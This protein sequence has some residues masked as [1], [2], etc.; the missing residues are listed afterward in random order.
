MNDFRFR[1][2]FCCFF[3]LC[4]FYY[5]Y[6]DR[7]SPLYAE[8]VTFLNPT[9][10]VTD[11]N[12]Y[13]AGL[14]D[15]Q[16]KVM[17]TYIN[18]DYQ[19]RQLDELCKENPAACKG[20]TP[21][22]ISPMGDALAQTAAQMLGLFGM[23]SSM[24]LPAASTT[25]TAAT[26][27]TA[28]TSTGSN[29]DYCSLIGVGTEAVARTNQ[30]MAQ[31]SLMAQGVLVNNQQAGKDQLLES[32]YKTKTSYNKLADNATIQAGGWGAT[33]TCY[34]V[35]SG[36]QLVQAGTGVG[37]QQAIM[38]GV[39]LTGATF[40]TGFY[41]FKRK[42]A[43][44]A[45]DFIQSVADRFKKLGNCNPI[46]E[47]ACYCAQPENQNDVK[48]CVP[49][50]YRKRAKSGGLVTSCVDNRLKSDPACL[51]LSTDSCYDAIFKDFPVTIGSDAKANEALQDSKQ[52]FRGNFSKGLAE[53]S[54]KERLAA[55]KKRLSELSPPEDPAILS[56]KQRE[57]AT[58][59][60]EFGIPR[61]WARYLAGRPKGE[62]DDYHANRLKME[63]ADKEFAAWSKRNGFNFG[64]R[65]ITFES[66]RRAMAQE[67]DETTK[68]WHEMNKKKGEQ[69]RNNSI[70]FPGQKAMEEGL[71]H[72]SGENLFERISY[73]YRTSTW[74]ELGA[75]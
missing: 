60:E 3:F 40:L 14:T 8:T 67:E 61:N 37:M 42:K 2:C 65:N 15:E 16:I 10:G 17:D 18:P 50:A 47:L 6:T 54:T 55:A 66:G 11:E 49:E 58:I 24:M 27:T 12:R 4:F 71:L 25:A 70:N 57:K 32:L 5:P 62:F 72:G 29:F 74:K 46:S 69:A 13:S 36:K 38:Q 52:L 21:Y 73:R 19:K 31:Q 34:V 51:C 23:M 1:F 44:E 28:A 22:A 64:N 59:M 41:Y 7:F 20:T 63:G 56:S 68:L 45:A 9:P 33:A 43:K 35:D 26:G 39:K 30:M 48:Y 53:S 75:Y